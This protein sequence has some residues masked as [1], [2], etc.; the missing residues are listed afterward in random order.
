MLCGLVPQG[1][2]AVKSFQE[3]LRKQAVNFSSASQLLARASPHFCCRTCLL[4]VMEVIFGEKKQ[5]SAQVHTHHFPKWG[6]THVRC[7]CRFAVVATKPLHVAVWL[8]VKSKAT[9]K[10]LYTKSKQLNPSVRPLSSWPIA[11]PAQR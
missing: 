3:A 1:K 11:V 10:L 9:K 5:I 8:A 2:I 6:T 7:S 4:K